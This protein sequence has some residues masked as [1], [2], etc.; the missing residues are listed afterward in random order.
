MYTN[1]GEDK[2]IPKNTAFFFVPC[3][4]LD[5]ECQ[6]SLRLV[7]CEAYFGKN[8]KKR[9]FSQMKKKNL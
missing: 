6:N 3:I 2:K 4:K 8:M 7:I 9:M 1:A 5:L